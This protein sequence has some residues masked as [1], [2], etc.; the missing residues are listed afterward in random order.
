MKQASHFEILAADGRGYECETSS[1][2]QDCAMAFEHVGVSY[3]ARVVFT[4]GTSQR[5]AA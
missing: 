3:T 5:I 2:L 4:D 1:D